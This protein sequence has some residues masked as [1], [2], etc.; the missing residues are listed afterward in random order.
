MSKIDLMKDDV[1]V[2][3]LMY[4]NDPLTS[5]QIM[6]AL[7]NGYKIKLMKAPKGINFWLEDGQLKSNSISYLKGLPY[8]WFNP[9]IKYEI[10]YD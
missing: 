10:D 4:Q 8:T 7:V 3:E 5:K 9:D 1:L 6:K 2:S